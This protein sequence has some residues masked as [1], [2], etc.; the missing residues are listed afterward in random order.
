[1]DVNVQDE[2]GMT[3]L[4]TASQFGPVELGEEL[5]KA[6]ASVN[7]RSTF[8]DTV[9]IWATDKKQ[10]KCVEKLLEFGANV[11]IQDGTTALMCASYKGNEK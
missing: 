5:I 1:M 10:L 2:K 4:M 9:L 3:A 11:N 7:I 8:G 6:G